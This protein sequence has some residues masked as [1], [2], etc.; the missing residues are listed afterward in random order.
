[1]A[2]ALTGKAGAVTWGGGAIN[3]KLRNWKLTFDGE[4]VSDRGAGEDW[5]SLLSL[6]SNWEVTF[7]AYALDQA[8]WSLSSTASEVTLINATSTISLK[9]KSADT[10]PVFTATGLCTQIE[11]VHDIE[12]PS[13]YTVTVKC[14]EGVAPTIDTTPAT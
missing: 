6:F 1:M 5:E 8:D 4:T 10:N 11:R 13:E 12:N 2:H 3:G 14:S 9:R 7:T